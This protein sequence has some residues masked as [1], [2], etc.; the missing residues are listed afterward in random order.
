[1]GNDDEAAVLQRGNETIQ[2]DK[3]NSSKISN[4]LA[5]KGNAIP[6]CIPENSNG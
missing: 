2:G 6:R 4:A 3:V 5:R 1:M